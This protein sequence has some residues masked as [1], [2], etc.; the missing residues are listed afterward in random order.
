MCWAWIANS[1]WIGVKSAACPLPATKLY[2]QSDICPRPTARATAWGG[3]KTV[4]PSKASKWH[5][6]LCVDFCSHKVW[7][8]DL[9]PKQISLKHV[10]GVILRFMA[11]HEL[12][13]VTWSDN[14]GQFTGVI[15]Q[16]LF[17]ATGCQSRTI[18]PGRPQSNGLTEKFNHLLDL[19]HRGHRDQLLTA[20]IALNSRQIPALGYTPEELWRL[21]RPKQSRW[22]HAHLRQAIHKDKAILTEEEWLQYLDSKPLDAKQLQQR[23]DTL[24]QAVVPVKKAIDSKKL[25]L[26]M[27]RQLRWQRKRRPQTT[28]P[29]LAGDR[30]VARAT[31][32][33]SK[34]APVKYECK[35]GAVREFTVLHASQ[36]FVQLK[37]DQTGEEVWKHESFLKAMP[38]SLPPD[39]Q[40]MPTPKRAKSAWAR[41]LTCYV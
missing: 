17:N 5:M 10:Q 1:L 40:N 6:L 38:R 3:M 22:Q 29:L 30:V 23:A 27:Q 16:A 41:I 4:T 37:E 21:L 26:K 35:D 2:R 12:P 39:D 31:Q 36:G 9:S 25:R 20:V 18:P 24:A 13:A 33:V 28:M 7:A 11:E 19:T 15:T 32:Y 8:W 34:T 14:G